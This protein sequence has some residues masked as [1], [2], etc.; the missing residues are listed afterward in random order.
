MQSQ[1]NKSNCCK[2]QESLV[3]VV[4]S[5]WC[6]GFNFHLDELKAKQLYGRLNY[7]NGVTKEVLEFI[8]ES[9]HVIRIT[10]DG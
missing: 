6:N 1:K 2:V 7:H 8:S 5:E 9:T 10:L 4:R 3:L